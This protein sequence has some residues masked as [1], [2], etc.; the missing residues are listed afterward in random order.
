MGIRFNDL[1]QPV[2]ERFVQI[3]S[4]PGRDPRLLH[5]T[6]AFGGIWVA[7]VGAV[8]SLIALVPIL[9]FTITR[10]QTVD[11]IHDKEVYLELAAAIAVFVLSITA[12]VFRFIWKP[13]PYPQGL[14]AFASY[15]VKAS[16][17]DL[18]LM[19]LADIGTPRIVTVR[20]NGGHVHTRLELGGPFTFYY[21]NDP[22][23]QASWGSIAAARATFRA[24][25]AARDAAAIAT[26]DPFVECTVSGA[27]AVPNQPPVPPRVTSVPTGI[28]I[29]R[30]AAAL[31]LGAVTAGAYYGLVDALFAEDRAAH[32][33]AERKRFNRR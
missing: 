22:A 24:M 27:W 32:D 19:S 26:V 17:G 11:P 33:L 6:K 2:R 28:K 14:Y 12:I 25:L 1:P 18:E 7:Y 3:T 9:E 5:H 15:L 30:W 29:G 20:R 31:V 8:L 10:G 16:G 13:P 23:A 21:P 4:A